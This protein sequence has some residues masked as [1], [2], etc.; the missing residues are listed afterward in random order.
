MLQTNLE[1]SRVCVI[2]Y[3]NNPQMLGD[4][5]NALL[6]DYS[7]LMWLLDLHVMQHENEE[8]EDNFTLVW[9]FQE[10][11]CSLFVFLDAELQGVIQDIQKSEVCCWVCSCFMASAQSSVHDC[12]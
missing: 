11:F 8:P 10:S 6:K 5:T 4:Q 3:P 2:T 1:E 12:R 9:H 7:S